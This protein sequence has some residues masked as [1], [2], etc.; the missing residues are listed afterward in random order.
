MPPRP[1][2]ERAGAQ[3]RAAGELNYFRDGARGSG[4][5]LAWWELSG[6]GAATPVPLVGY[7]TGLYLG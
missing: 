5:S 2:Q 7:C 1:A 4:L 3:G 6:V